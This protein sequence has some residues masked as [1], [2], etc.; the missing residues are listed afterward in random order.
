ML[1]LVNSALKAVPISMM[2]HWM[3]DLQNLQHK[4]FTLN[5]RA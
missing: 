3:E 1:S 5:G 2:A 4:T